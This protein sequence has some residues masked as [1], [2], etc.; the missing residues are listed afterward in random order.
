[1]PPFLETTFEKLRNS[2]I[3]VGVGLVLSLAMVVVG[4]VGVRVAVVRLPADHFVRPP[5]PR[6]LRQKIARTS[7]G[8]LL[9]A[10][11]VAM[12]VLPGQGLLTILVG[13][14]LLELPIQRRIA[15]W[16]VARPRLCELV[17]GWRRKAGQAPFELPS[18][19]PPER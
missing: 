19:A 15:G 5:G 3:A 6:P 1:M 16:L 7:L 8:L 18:S 14:V 13:L 2:P 9:I 4:I 17:N 12:L 10:A 11:G